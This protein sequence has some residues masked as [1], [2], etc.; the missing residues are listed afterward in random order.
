LTRWWRLA[1]VALA[2]AFTVALIVAGAAY[3]RAPASLPPRPVGKRPQLMLLTRLPIVFPER[4]TLKAVKSPVLTTLESRYRIEP[5]SVASRSSLDG[6]K[7][8]L[9]AQPQAQPAEMLVDLD[10]WVHNG[11]RVLLLADPALEWP[12]ERPLGNLLR[13]PFA[14][15]D[16]GLLAHWGLRLD[17]PDA[18]ASKQVRVGGQ[19]IRTQAPGALVAI[20]RACSVESRFVARCSVGKGEAIVIA[21]ADFI[22]VDDSNSPN[23]QLLLRELARLEQ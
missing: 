12:S 8:L 3:W 5:I 7:L 4:L 1:A 20:G 2:V 22:D 17:S 6:R 19:T 14:F 23:L 18:L 15:A 10:R 13:P 21:D 9:M 11:G 16:T